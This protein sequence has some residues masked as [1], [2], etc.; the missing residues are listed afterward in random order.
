MRLGALKR[1][2]F[3]ILELSTEMFGRWTKEKD[4]APLRRSCHQRWPCHLAWQQNPEQS[5]R[6]RWWFLLLLSLTERTLREWQEGSSCWLSPWSTSWG[7]TGKILLIPAQ[8]TSVT[9][10]GP[11][12][13]KLA[14]LWDR[15]V[16]LGTWVL[17]SP[18]PPTACPAGQCWSAWPGGTEDP[19]CW[20]RN[21]EG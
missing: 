15:A 20:N 12:Q 18:E 8:T 19:G 4:Y 5:C 6:D 2:P 9:W 13:R 21:W 11:A 14:L 3:W 16:W 1:K 17:A 7:A 10:Q